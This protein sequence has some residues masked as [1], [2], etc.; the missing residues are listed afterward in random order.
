MIIC[1]NSE[2]TKTGK[3]GPTYLVTESYFILKIRLY[4]IIVSGRRVF[5]SQIY[6]FFNAKHVRYWI[7]QFLKFL[8]SSLPNFH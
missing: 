3:V 8:C 6:I 5:S 1:V 4:L 7:E 2:V